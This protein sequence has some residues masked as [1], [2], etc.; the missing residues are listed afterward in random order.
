MKKED[1]LLVAAE[2]ILLY[3]VILYGFSLAGP[4][5]P[6]VELP[7]INKVYVALYLTVGFAAV[8]LPAVTLLPPF[9]SYTFQASAVSSLLALLSILV[10]PLTM[11]ILD[12]PLT[13]LSLVSSVA[14]ALA[15]VTYKRR[16]ARPVLVRWSPREIAVVSVF[17]AL[18]AILTSFVGSM[19]PS[20]TGGYTHIG[21]VGIFLAALL[22]GPKVGGAVGVIGPLIADLVIGYPRW[23]VSV[24]AHGAE[25]VIA[26]LGKDRKL[27]VRVAALAVAGFVM[28]F[29]Y[30]IV[31][32]Y[33][34]GY[35]P[36]MI[37]FARDL[38]GQAGLSL[39]I[40]LV[41]Y[42][43]VKRAVGTLK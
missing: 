20:P 5:S 30:F 37:S 32:I 33:I 14:F 4:P 1:L 43:P 31:N 3:S 42:E 12:I 40:T 2:V 41:L 29:T 10:P 6:K 15:A 24:L 19:F 8:I 28:A 22:F 34:K 18:T 23:F 36:A 21:D 39:I 26:G 16:I 17:S 11:S 35:A 27:L 7:S 9:S 13:L 38:F 25:G